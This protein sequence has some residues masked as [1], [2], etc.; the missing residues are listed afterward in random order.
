VSGASGIIA[1]SDITPASGVP[2]LE[3]D[4]KPKIKVN[5]AL[6]KETVVLKLNVRSSGRGR[7]GCVL[8]LSIKY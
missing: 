1:E 6:L 7:G 3:K 5:P 2:H 4:L 8:I